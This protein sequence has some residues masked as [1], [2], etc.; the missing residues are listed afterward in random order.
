MIDATIGSGVL[1]AVPVRVTVA[2]TIGSVGVAVDVGG[3]P[4]VLVGVAAGV[5][6]VLVGVAGGVPD[7]LVGVAAACRM[8]WSA[9]P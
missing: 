4:D 3:V 2:V 7:V 8:C 1:V 9:S 6:D 5:P